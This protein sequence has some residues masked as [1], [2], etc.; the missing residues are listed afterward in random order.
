MFHNLISI[1]LQCVKF[2]SKSFDSFLEVTST[3]NSIVTLHAI[4]CTHVSV[5]HL[6]KALSNYVKIKYCILDV[7]ILS[8]V[9]LHEVAEMT[10]TLA[11]QVN[12]DI[13]LIERIPS[14]LLHHHVD[15]YRSLNPTGQ[16]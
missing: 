1:T 7:E 9:E 11:G 13:N 15:A 12:L 10:N 8:V 6:D 16:H 4:C 14:M 2:T 5:K 3:Y